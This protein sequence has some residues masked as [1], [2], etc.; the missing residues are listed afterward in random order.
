MMTRLPA[1]QVTATM[2][3]Q[4]PARAPPLTVFTA[5]VAAG[6]ANE[7]RNLQEQQ[8][9]RDREIHDHE[10]LRV[11][12]RKAS[13]PAM[14]PPD[15]RPARGAGRRGGEPGPR[16]PPSS[17]EG[18]TTTHGTTMPSIDTIIALPS[19]GSSPNCHAQ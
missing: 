4:A 6:E 5:H 19:D 18:P 12:V 14:T 11:V 9:Q 8:R 3:I 17:A 13:Q 15:C 1:S 16:T 2:R 7:D 10:E